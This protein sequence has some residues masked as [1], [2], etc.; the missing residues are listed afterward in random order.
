MCPLF[1][2]VFLCVR[3]R[4][5]YAHYCALPVCH[6]YFDKTGTGYLRVEDLRRI[7]H[8]LGECLPHRSVKALVHGVADPGGSWRGERVYYR[9]VQ[10]A[11]AEQRI[12]GYETICSPQ[13][14]LCI[15]ELAVPRAVWCSMARRGTAGCM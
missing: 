12:I 10:G 6:R 14:C 9:C 7:I 13:N 2:E 11:A 5:T 3:L 8:N 4:T 15:T 1:T